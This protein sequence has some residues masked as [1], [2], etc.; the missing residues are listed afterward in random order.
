MVKGALSVRIRTRL[1]QLLAPLEPFSLDVARHLA[2]CRRTADRAALL[3]DGDPLTIARNCA[4][5][6]EGTAHLVAAIAQPGWI[7][8]RARLGLGPR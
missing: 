1:E 7:P 4:E 6:E 3:L 8:L 5:R 2:A